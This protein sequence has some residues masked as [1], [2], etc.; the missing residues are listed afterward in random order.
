MPDTPTTTT[1]DEILEV[2]AAGD[3]DKLIISQSQSNVTKTITKANLLQNEIDD[4]ESADNELDTKITKI[5]DGTTTLFD[6]TVNGDTTLGNIDNDTVTT[7]GDLTVGKNLTVNGN[8]KVGNSWIDKFT[9]EGSIWRKH[10]GDWGDTRSYFVHIHEFTLTPTTSAF[11]WTIP[12]QLEDN[13]YSDV[14]IINITAPTILSN[15]L[16]WRLDFRSSSNNKNIL[17]S[18][19]SNAIN[20]LHEFTI[21]YYKI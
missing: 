16:G 14:R 9:V 2:T 13:E 5:V 20:A 11:Y 12:F 19:P 18:I 21:T 6:L 4:R 15:Q 1:I 17:F 3:N 8:T 10:R 7:L